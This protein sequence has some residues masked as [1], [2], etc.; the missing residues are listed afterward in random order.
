MSGEGVTD[1]IEALYPVS[2]IL[3]SCSP[4]D[5]RWRKIRKHHLESLEGT[6]IWVEVRK[7]QP[8]TFA[9]IFRRRSIAG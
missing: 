8:A 1:V 5:L 3:M 2:A 7:F 6:E 4:F 9:S